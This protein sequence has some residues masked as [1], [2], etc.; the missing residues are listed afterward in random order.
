M[1]KISLR[2]NYNKSII[3]P[4][5]KITDVTVIHHCIAFE[6]T[7]YIYVPKYG[8]YDSVLPTQIALEHK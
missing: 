5:Q 2:I 3:K 7:F 1:G 4:I 6:T 8:D